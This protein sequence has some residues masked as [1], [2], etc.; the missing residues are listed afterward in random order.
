MIITSTKT[1]DKTDILIALDL[2]IHSNSILNLNLDCYNLGKLHETQVSFQSTKSRL[3]KF[4]VFDMDSTL[5]KQ[6]CIDEIAR[7]ANVG[8]QVSKITELAMQGEIDFS[9]SLNRRVA[10][11][12][13]VDESVYEEIK[14]LIEFNLGAEM[15]CRVLKKM[16]VR[17]AVVSGGFMPLALFVKDRLGLDYAFANTLEAVDGKLTG[18]VLGS[19]VD[20]RR[21]SELLMMLA[22]DL[23]LSLEET[24]AVGDGANDLFMMKVASVGVA[25]SAKERVQKE[26]DARIMS[27]E[28]V[29]FLMGLTRG[30]IDEIKE[31][32]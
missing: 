10:L 14:K 27:L 13:G 5:I 23:Q 1:L 22:K 17:M 30:E 6:E 2:F 16:G 26:A 11:L 28:G 15:V 29:L 3:K 8:H 9:E 21:K 7:I 31:T 25:Y 18:K 20:G 4:V 24:M 19:I 12:N 32:L